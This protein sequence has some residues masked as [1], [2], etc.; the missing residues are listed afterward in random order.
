LYSKLQAEDS[1]TGKETGVEVGVEVGGWIAVTVGG[2]VSV[3]VEPGVS[4]GETGVSVWKIGVS[5]GNRDWVVV[6]PWEQP[7]I[8][9]VRIIVEMIGFR[10]SDMIFLLGY[11]GSAPKNALKYVMN[12]T[13]KAEGGLVATLRETIGCV[14]CVRGTHEGTSTCHTIL[15]SIRT[16]RIGLRI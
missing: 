14:Q 13:P 1:K 6:S 4:V 8:R 9:M 7:A 12:S 2:G 11:L 10:R 15:P 3:S 16:G 5:E